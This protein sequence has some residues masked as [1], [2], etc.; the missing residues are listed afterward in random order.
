M[1]IINKKLLKQPFLL[2]DGA[3]ATELERKGADLNDPLWSAKTLLEQPDLIYSTHLDYLNA[4]ADII[5]TCTYQ[6]TFQGFEKRGLS[7]AE[8][9]EV[10]KQ[11]VE[12]AKNAKNTFL[13][14][15]QIATTPLIAGSI[16]SYGAF[17]AD[18]SEYKGDYKIGKKDLKE[19]HHFRMEWLAECGIDLFIFETIPSIIEAKA[20]I[21]LLGEMNGLSALFSFSCKNQMQI[22]DGHKMSEAARLVS[23]CEWVIAIGTNCLNPL[24][25]GSLLNEMDGIDK[26]LLVYPNDGRFWDANK[27]CWLSSSTTF[28]LEQLWSEWINKGVKIIGGCC[29]TSPTQIAQLVNFRKRMVN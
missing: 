7:L 13:T 15:N 4:G 17:L 26:P 28:K 12:L 10:F 29:N 6:A 2:L 19:F 24:W 8:S 27:K 20:I 1:N 5:C 23:D 16:G 14:K 3:M 21:E 9:K 22:S 25:V 18:G 11:S